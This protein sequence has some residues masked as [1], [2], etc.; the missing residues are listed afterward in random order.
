MQGL[1]VAV[2]FL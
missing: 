2:H 1:H